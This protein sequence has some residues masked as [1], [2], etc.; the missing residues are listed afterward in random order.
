MF[1][2]LIYLKFNYNKIWALAASQD[3]I[4]SGESKCQR[5][6]FRIDAIVE[7]KN[8]KGNRNGL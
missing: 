8:A 4:L 6:Q 1:G 7:I 5:A 2:S 3:Y